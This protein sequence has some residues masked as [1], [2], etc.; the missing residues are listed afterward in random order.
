MINL[1][2]LKTKKI[3]LSVISRYFVLFFNVGRTFLL[4]I[5]M[6]KNDFG[7]LSYFLLI[8]DYTLNLILCG[9]HFSVNLRV[10]LKK[11]YLSQDLLEN[12]KLH[13]SYNYLFT[14]FIINFLILIFIFSFI[15]FFFNSFLRFSIKEHIIIYFLFVFFI[16]L[17]NISII[18]LR[19]I[20]NYNSL[21]IM[22][23][24]FSFLTI[25]FICLIYYFNILSIKNILLSIVLSA[26]I[27]IILGKLPVKILINN[28]IKIRIKFSYLKNF[29]AL[30]FFLFLYDILDSYFIG[31]DRLII[32]LFL[33][34]SDIADL[35]ISFSLSK[36]TLIFFSY[37]LYLLNP[38]ILNFFSNKI[39]NK[40]FYE[41]FLKYQKILESILVTV[42]IISL[43]FIPL[44]LSYI[45]KKYL[46][47]YPLYIIAMLG[48]I[49]KYFGYMTINSLYSKKRFKLII[50]SILISIFLNIVI[51]KYFISINYHELIYF[52]IISILSI[53]LLVFVLQ[54]NLIEKVTFDYKIS[55]LFKSFYKLFILIIFSISIIMTVKTSILQSFLITLVAM[56]LY[57]FQVTKDMRDI[58]YFIVKKKLFQK[59]K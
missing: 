52:L 44:I 18:H 29:F 48:L 41:D 23:L 25:L 3:L 20:K 8:C 7:D 27:S 10:S 43:W 4:G 58:Y 54:F 35:V 57:S 40:E 15:F 1:S 19:L 24:A 59:N 21:W 2:F 16:S 45:L 39:N 47:I 32:P 22:E 12:Q 42:F 6:T 5:V 55:F 49:I 33:N 14:I 37:S 30:S 53:F 13:I 26:F 46:N 28:L 38:L 17:R 11:N 51:I 56:V 50:F 34:N 36:V 31:V 9:C